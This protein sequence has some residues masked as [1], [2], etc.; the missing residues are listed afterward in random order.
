MALASPHAEE[1]PPQRR[2]SQS[3]I[4]KEVLIFL[5]K[6]ACRNPKIL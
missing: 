5:S 3:G 4:E 2:P 6:K 1:I